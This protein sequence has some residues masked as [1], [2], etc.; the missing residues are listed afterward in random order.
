MEQQRNIIILLSEGRSGT[1][2]LYRHIFANKQ[3]KPEPYKDI[4]TKRRKLFKKSLLENMKSFEQSKIIHIKPSHMW[5][6]TCGMLTTP[7]LV[8]VC[9]ECGINNFIVITRKNILA[10]LA[11]DPKMGSKYKK[12]IEISP[13]RLRSKLEK[14]DKFEQQAI[15]YIKSKKES[16]LVSLVYEEDIKLDINIA[17]QKLLDMFPWLPKWYKTYSESVE[18]TKKLK[19]CEQNNNLLDKRKIRERISNVDEL[20]LILKNRGALWMLDA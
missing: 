20:L 10:R 2:G 11:S 6:T 14:K 19:A 4:P 8:D 5:S 1:N 12:Q 3:R 18:E 17:C 16:K 7:E 15:A 13:A 9:M